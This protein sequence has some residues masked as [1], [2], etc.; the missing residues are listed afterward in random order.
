MKNKYLT[1]QVKA[2]NGEVVVRGSE[3]N[4]RML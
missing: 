2:K 4:K 1:P 3:V